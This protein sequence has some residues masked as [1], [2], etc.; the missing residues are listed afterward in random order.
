MFDGGA[1]ADDARI[2]ADMLADKVGIAAVFSGSDETGY[3]YA[4]VSRSEDVRPLGK[5]LNEAC[6]GRGGG[7][8]DMVQGSVSASRAEIESFW[9][10]IK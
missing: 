2:F 10:S 9:N 3:K 5:R 8:P 7:K 6:S 1:S 4:V